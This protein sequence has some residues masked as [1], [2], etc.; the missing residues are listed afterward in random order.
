MACWVERTVLCLKHF[1]EIKHGFLCTKTI[2]PP[3]LFDL[4]CIFVR[5][6]KAGGIGK[7]KKYLQKEERGE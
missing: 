4:L 1:W 6:K 5:L 3:P 7:N 2:R